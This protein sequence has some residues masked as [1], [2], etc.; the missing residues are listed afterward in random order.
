M[1]NALLLIVTI[2]PIALAGCGSSSSTGSGGG[3]GGGGS[4]IVGIWEPSEGELR[5]M[6]ME[7]TSAGKIVMHMGNDGKK[8][9]EMGTYKVEGDKMTLS[10]KEGEKEDS[11]TWTI[12]SLSDDELVTVDKRGKESKMK[13]RK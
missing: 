6:A 10:R 8:S 2:F 13:R 1:K 11:E 4:K 12:K 9:M 5:G 3:P 7:F